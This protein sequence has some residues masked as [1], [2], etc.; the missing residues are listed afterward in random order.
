MNLHNHPGIYQILN[1]QVGDTVTHYIYVHLQITVL[2][3]PDIV[4]AE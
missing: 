3:W 4:G 1:S 2:I